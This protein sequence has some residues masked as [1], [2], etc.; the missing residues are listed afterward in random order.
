MENTVLHENN[1]DI[2]QTSKKGSIL[3]WVKFGFFLLLI[4]FLIR[5]SIG[6]TTVSGFSMQPTFH[7]GNIVFEEKVSKFFTSPEIGDV[8]IINKHKREQGYK[9]IK[10]VLGVEGDTV[11]IK[12]GIVF[13]NQE[14]VPEVMTEGLSNDMEAIKVPEDHIFVMGDNRAPG[15]SIDSRD[16]SVGPMPLSSL[17]GYV[18]FSINP[19]GSIPKPLD[20]NE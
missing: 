1:Q 17:D 7:D 18:L 12:N 19:F 9:I 14:A 16:P 3:E 6:I 10:R 20:L 8:V 11:E 15:E 2:K 5:N 13:V 4:V